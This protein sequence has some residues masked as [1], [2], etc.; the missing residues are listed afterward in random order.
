MLLPPCLAAAFAVREDWPTH[1][2]SADWGA[3][4]VLPMPNA[5]PGAGVRV[6]CAR[7]GR[8]KG[9][10]AEHCWI[11]LNDAG[12]TA[13]ERYE[14]VGWGRPVRKN[15]YAA[16]GY[17]YSNKP[18]IVYVDTG[19][20]A[21]TT[22]PRIR[23]AIAAYPHNQNGAYTVWPGPNSNSFVA[24]I[25]R[26]VS[27]FDPV[28]PNTAIGKDYLVSAD[29]LDVTPSN[30]GW[31][32]SFGGYAGVTFARAEGVEVNLLGLIWGVDGSGRLK[33]PVVGEL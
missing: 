27:G 32:V 16:D 29:L 11:V 2:R 19:P 28:L 18:R 5:E 23:H 20:S 7:T 21:A 1:W 14:V 24:E 6:L 22:L 26:R 15:A 17:W 30:S 33:F 12:A 4:G 9:V 25:A 8:W 31:Q 13:Y 3:S 10:L